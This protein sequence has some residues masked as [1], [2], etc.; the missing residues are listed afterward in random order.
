MSQILIC[1]SDDFTPENSDHFDAVAAALQHFHIP[2]SMYQ[3]RGSHVPDFYEQA[4]RV[5]FEAEQTGFGELGPEMKALR[6]MLK[7]GDDQ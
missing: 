5:V 2:A 6:T 4:K 3:V 7:L 1:L